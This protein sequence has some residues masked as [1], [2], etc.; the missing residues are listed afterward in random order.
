M[1]AK[2]PSEKHK[3]QENNQ[4]SMLVVCF[5]LDIFVKRDYAPAFTSR[6]ACGHIEE[7]HALISLSSEDT[8]AIW[9]HAH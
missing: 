3:K 7:N 6:P 4:Y 2:T 5:D 1:K 8:E 9:V